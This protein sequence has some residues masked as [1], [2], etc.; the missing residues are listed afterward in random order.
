MIII[1]NLPG[2]SIALA[3]HFAMKRL[4]LIVTFLKIIDPGFC[5]NHDL[6]WCLGYGNTSGDPML[7]SM[8]LSFQHRPPRVILQDMV[9]FSGYGFSCSDSL[10]HLVFY[11]NGLDIRNTLNEIMENGDTINAGFYWQSANQSGAYPSDNRT[12]VFPAPGLP[13]HYYVVHMTTDVTVNGVYSLHPLRFTLIDMKANNGLGKVVLKNQILADSFGGNN[14]LIG[15]AAVKHGNGRDWWVITG[16]YNTPEQLIFL[17]SPSG[18]SGPFVQT[19][20]PA[21][22]LPEGRGFPLFTPDGNT[23]I[24][25]DAANG[26]RIFNFDRCSGQ[27]SNL[28]II[29][30]S[31]P[32]IAFGTVVSPNSRFMY[33]LSFPHL[34]QFDL[35][36]ND[37]GASMDTVALY[38]GFVSPSPPFETAFNFPQLGPDGKIYLATT[39]TTTA[40]HVIHRPDLPGIACDVRQHG[41]ILPKFNDHTMPRF[42]NYRLGE[43]E[44]SPCDTLNAQKSDDGFFFTEYDF[45]KI[46]VKTGFKL[47]S[48]VPDKTQSSQIYFSRPEVVLPPTFTEWFYGRGKVVRR[49]LFLDKIQP[50]YEKN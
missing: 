31:T 30:F 44:D 39:S 42:P 23:Y 50:V 47:M 17:F 12:V 33:A 9:D 25:P 20:G 15:P 13:D 22:P 26:P 43:W 41:F 14:N 45:S 11:S 34:V 38:D 46:D 6:N 4:F 1:N 2:L 49:D 21:Y 3:G 18:V 28:R 24:R 10:G 36:A 29:P 27:L 40:L 19:I 35:W 37:I 8:I 16:R 48:P 5:Q 32:F 7:G